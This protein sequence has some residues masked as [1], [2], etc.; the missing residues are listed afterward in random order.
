MPHRIGGDHIWTVRDHARLDVRTYCERIAGRNGIP[1]PRAPIVALARPLI[2]HIAWGGW[3]VGC[4]FCPNEQF[5]EHGAGVT[6]CLS[7]TCPRPRGD[8]W[9]G[10]IDPPRDD[11]REAEA[12]LT[13][14]VS[15]VTDRR[16][17]EPE[18]G[19]DGRPILMSLMGNRNW[20]PDLGETVADL[21]AENVEHGWA[22]PA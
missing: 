10:V 7:P 11:I 4:P 15:T 3:Q 6:Y 13:L 9:L 17:G 16:T 2:A 18:I 20:M 19:L 14:R 22:V 21:R 12:I 1:P 5:H 8:H